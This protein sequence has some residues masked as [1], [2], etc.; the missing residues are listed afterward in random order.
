LNAAV[1]EAERRQEVREAATAWRDAEAID[2][3]TLRAIVARYADD[4]VRF[5]LWLRILAGVA[6]FIGGVALAVLVVLILWANSDPATNSLEFAIVAVISTI[7]TEWMTRSK[8]RAQ[9][10][11][12]EATAVL[13]VLFATVAV[14]LQ[15]RG[16]P[17]NAILLTATAICLAAGWRWGYPLFALAATISGACWLA[18][19]P[20]GRTLWLLGSIANVYIAERAARSERL[21]PS[22][23]R[24]ARVF[25]AGALVAG[26]LA[27]NL[28]SVDE[29]YVEAVVGD[30]PTHG[31]PAWI[32]LAAS[33]ATALAPIVVLAFGV[34]RK[35]REARVLG[36]LFLVA[37]LA[38]LR[39]YRPIL[40][41]WLALT[42]GGAAAWAIA[43]AIKRWLD[44]APGRERY[45]YTTDPLFVPRRSREIAEV[46]AV[47]ASLGPAPPR[48]SG[49]GFQPGGGVSGGGGAAGGP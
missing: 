10:G 13:A 11:I 36:A 37:S 47:T 24:S 46:A 42:L 39:H 44:N 40:P 15:I 30:R 31:W 2:D 9:G 35:N 3:V 1:A 18:R 6:T 27:I 43:L 32:R 29:S 21:A 26:Y 17:I 16:F 49:G 14:A 23:R 19:F 45:G 25:L 28:W 5:A 12:E 38:T 22:H 33:V 34:V 8:R 20:H 48:T 7:A 41:T 4:R